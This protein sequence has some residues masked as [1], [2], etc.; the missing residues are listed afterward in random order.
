MGTSFGRV[1]MRIMQV[2]WNRGKATALEITKVLNEYEP[3]D[4]R[5]VQTLLRQLE[6]KASVAHEKLGRAFVYYPAMTE[7]SAKKNLI[8]EFVDTMFSGSVE[9]L[10][11]AMV[12]NK[13]LSSKELDELL[14][15]VDKEKE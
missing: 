9:S 13:Y 4:H 10:V 1:Q 2:L 5:N 15:L 12:K 8:S 3:I 7:K 11:S 6:Q 14:S